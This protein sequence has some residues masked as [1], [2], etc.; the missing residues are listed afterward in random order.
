MQHHMLRELRQAVR[1][2]AASKGFSLVVV[3]TLA[4]AIG[5]NTTIFTV[6]NAVLL[7]PLPFADPGRLVTIWERNR[8]EGQD[9]VEV[10]GLTFLDW[11]ARATTFDGV[12]AW[13][14]RG[15]TM[16]DGLEAERV[17]SVELTPDVFA[18]LGVPAHV[19]SVLGEADGRPGAERRVILSAGAWARRFGSDPGVVGRAVR[20]DEQSYTIAGVMPADFQ[21]PPA[22]PTVE[23]WSPLVLDPGAQPSRP[24]RMYQV[25]ARMTPGVSVEQAQAD[26]DAVADG[27]A[28]EHPDSNAGWGASL[29][30]AHEQVVGDI[31]STLWVLFGAVVVVLLIACA[32]VANLVLARSARAS[33]DFAVRA[34]FGASRSALVRRS[35]I[36]SAVLALAGGGAGIALA[37]WGT[38]ALR[39]IVPSSVPRA[40]QITLDWAVLAFAAGVTAAAALAFGLVPA[41]RAM[42]S[43]VLEVLQEGGRSALGSRRARRAANALVAAEVALALMLLVGAGLLAQSFVRLVSVDPGFRTSGV[44][45][46]HV[47]LPAARYGPAASKRQFFDDLMERVHALPGVRSAGA[48][49]ALP[50]SPLGLDFD[51]PFTIDGL[52]A[53]SPAERPRANYRGVMAGYFETMGIALMEGRLFD[54]FDGRE[55]GP[56]V[57]VIN[58][59]AA[60][61]YFRDVGPIDRVIRM[62]MAGDLTIVG[63]VADVRHYGL[64]AAPEVE[65]FVPYGQFALSEMQVVVETDAAAGPIAPAMRAVIAGID[66]AVPMGKVSAMEDLLAETVAQPRFNTALLVG[67]ALCAALLAAIG[68]Y[69]VVSYAVARRTAE[70]GLRMALGADAA[71]TFR[72]VVGGAVRVVGAGVAIGLVGAALLGESLRGLLFGVTPL[73][74]ATYVAAGSALLAFGALAASVPARRAARV[75]PVEALRVE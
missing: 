41:W 39:T 57:A 17:V 63:V 72:H 43:N 74:P 11:R 71:A 14:Y 68:V 9:R 1:G 36:D 40:D 33:K 8:Q 69:G 46:I 51:L 24:H 6:V 35:L 7:R 49:S 23:F 38:R 64:D 54:G 2:L 37:G 75:D 65:V 5:V 70:I 32:N 66:S 29:V 4:I 18:V 67:L 56:R 50:M 45:A 47:A 20:L 28:R 60:R 48:V 21:F 16:T 55:G 30:P 58:E 19:G 44:T 62:P 53:T 73:D 15:F 26:M 13:R 22:D 61:R 10:A 3:L 27:I 59:T 12:G 34:A 31:G 52:E 42:R 25:I